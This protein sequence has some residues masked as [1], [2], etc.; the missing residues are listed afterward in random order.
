MYM[1]YTSKSQKCSS[2]SSKW[3]GEVDIF[4]VK[5]DETR[6]KEEIVVGKS[7]PRF[8]ELFRDF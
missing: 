1:S 7:V 5:I 3:R 8:E 2:P 6:M 4:S